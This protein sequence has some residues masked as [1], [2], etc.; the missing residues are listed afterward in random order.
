MDDGSFL[1]LILLFFYLIFQN[2]SKS[3]I[4]IYFTAFYHFSD[5]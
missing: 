1:V 2:Y 5:Y 3:S 4:F